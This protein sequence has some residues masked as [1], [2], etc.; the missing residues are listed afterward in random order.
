MF[1]H[2]QVQHPGFSSCLCH[3]FATGRSISYLA[4]DFQCLGLSVADNKSTYS[5]NDDEMKQYHIY[6]TAWCLALKKFPINGKFY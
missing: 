1:Q 6:V 5:L 3:I 2:S 4:P